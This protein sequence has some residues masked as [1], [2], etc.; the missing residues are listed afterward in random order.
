MLYVIVHEGYV[1]LGPM[2]FNARRFTE[3][4]QEDCNTSYIFTQVE[5]TEVITID[6]KT[7]LYPVERGV[8]PD[9]NPVKEYLHGPIWEYTDTAA[10]MNYEVCNLEIGA[11]RS[12]LKQR[13]ATE[14]WIRQTS[15]ITVNINGTDYP[16]KTDNDTKVTIGQYIASELNEVVWKVN[17]DT[18]V[19]LSNS[20]LVT[21]F[22]QIITHIQSAFDWEA[23]KCQEIDTT[24]FDNLDQIAIENNVN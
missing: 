8:Q 16:F 5:P 7:K 21:I 1:V 2:T 20:Q 14:R 17:Q 18:Y 23:N 9:F 15:G 24:E 12:F 6:D 11:A 22:N 3:V 13:A 10:I 19:T 4:L